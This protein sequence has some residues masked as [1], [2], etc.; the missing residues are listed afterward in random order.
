MTTSSTSIFTVP[1]GVY[2]WARPARNSEVPAPFV[3]SEIVVESESEP[4]T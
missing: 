4:S 2:V 1:V 3:A